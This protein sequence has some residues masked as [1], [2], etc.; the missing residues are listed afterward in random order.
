MVAS[1]HM[2][3]LTAKVAGV[4][5]IIMVSPG[6]S[7]G[8]INQTVL[9]AAHI[10]GINKIFRVGGAQAIAALAYGTQS[11]PKV[12]V[13]TGPGNIFVT[14]AKKQV[15]GLVGIDSLAGPS[16]VIIIADNTEKVEK[17]AADLLAQAEHDPLAAS[18]L[19]TTD[20]GLLTKVNC[21]IE[22]QLHNLRR[23]E[24]CRKSLNDWGLIVICNNLETCAALSNRFAPE[25]L[26][27][28]IANPLQLS[29]I[30]ISEPTR[31]Y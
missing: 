5:E 10:A 6:S 18:I 20:E 25:H 24:I 30:H 4:K 11:I 19:L 9:A 29:L 17:L 28:L 3:V 13:I 1:A 14:L 7:S 31:P 8:E 26:E 22:K 12:D 23:S 27:L 2:S 16:E 15:Y 21:E